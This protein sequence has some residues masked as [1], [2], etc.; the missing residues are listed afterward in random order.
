MSQEHKDKISSHHKLFGVGKWMMGRQ[1][2]AETKLKISEFHKGK[3]ISHEVR[4]KISK[5]HTGMRHSEESKKKI[6]NSGKGRITSEET[7]EKLRI[8]TRRAIENGKICVKNWF[9]FNPW[10]CIYIDALSLDTGWNLQ[11][12]ENGGEIRCLWYS[13]DGY[14]KERNIAF[15]YD[16]QRHFNFD[17]TLKE[18]D[19]VRMQKIVKELNCQFYR[20]NEPKNEL[21]RYY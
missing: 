17:G 19:V 9:C 3:C 15:E 2:S 6:S 7:K 18:C 21:I 14:D 4:L 5:T 11:H 13:L 12:A 16:E 8:A 20:Y 1:P 10:S